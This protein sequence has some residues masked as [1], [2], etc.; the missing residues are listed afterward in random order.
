MPKSWKAF[1]M[2]GVA[3]VIIMAVVFRV[4]AVRSFVTGS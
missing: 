3:V 4:S 1:V 2:L